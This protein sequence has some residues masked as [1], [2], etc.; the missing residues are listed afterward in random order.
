MG[1]QSVFFFITFLAYFF[2]MILAALM[3]DESNFLAIGNLLSFDFKEQNELREMERKRC[4]MMERNE[5]F[6]IAFFKV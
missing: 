6:P 3:A 5:F 1:V 2:E 4:E